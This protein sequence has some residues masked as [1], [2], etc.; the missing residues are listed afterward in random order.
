MI[1]DLAKA[2]I[3]ITFLVALAGGP[4]SRALFG[5]GS[6]ADARTAARLIRKTA[7]GRYR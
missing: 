7:Q 3:S 4:R 1:D 5:F 2:G 6:D